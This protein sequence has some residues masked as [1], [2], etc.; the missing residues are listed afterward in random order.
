VHEAKEMW[1]YGDGGVSG[2]ANYAAAKGGVLG[3]TKA[4]AK[5]F[6]T[7]GVTGLSLS[8]LL[9]LLPSS[10]LPLPSALP[11]PRSST[12]SLFLSL[13]LPPPPFLFYCLLACIS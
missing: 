13:P 4:M 2:Q 9:L 12:L 10:L 3:M 6:A 5:E 7:R 11:P 8:S 1:L